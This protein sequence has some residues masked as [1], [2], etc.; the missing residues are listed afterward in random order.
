MFGNRRP[1]DISFLPA[2]ISESILVSHNL[3]IYDANLSVH[4]PAEKYKVSSCVTST[5]P[6]ASLLHA[7]NP[8]L[9][10]FRFSFLCMH[11][12]DFLHM[13]THIGLFSY[14]VI[15]FLS[16]FIYF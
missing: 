11:F 9:L 3:E 2:N 13:Y 5:I 14:S 16:L 1:D 12:V 10:S 8:V 15:Y 7:G 4:I 6:T